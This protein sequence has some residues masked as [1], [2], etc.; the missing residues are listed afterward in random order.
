MKLSI[1][2]SPRMLSVTA[3]PDHPELQ[4]A[5][6]SVSA[7]I[8]C[9]SLQQELRTSWTPAMSDDT[10]TATRNNALFTTAVTRHHH[11][12]TRTPPIC[13]TGALP[14]TLLAQ[15]TGCSTSPP[16]RR[17][18]KRQRSQAVLRSPWPVPFWCQQIWWG[19]LHTNYSQVK[20]WCQDWTF[21]N[22]Q[23]LPIVFYI[24]LSR[25]VPSCSF[26]QAGLVWL[27]STITFQRLSL[28]WT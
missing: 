5:I 6:R 14:N 22:L 9:R 20:L 7:S 21:W 8:G 25:V 16:Q 10:S 4:R 28:A 3:L 2:K 19:I 15:P 27:I 11:W 26:T 23:L 24:T 1:F 17:F 12:C 18:T 13:R